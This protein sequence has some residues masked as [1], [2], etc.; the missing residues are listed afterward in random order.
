MLTPR[1]SLILALGCLWHLGYLE[2]FR[3]RQRTVSIPFPGNVFGPIIPTEYI[4]PGLEG[5]CAATAGC[6][7]NT[8]CASAG[9]PKSHSRPK[10]VASAG[11]GCTV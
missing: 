7:E 11:P 3:S 8:G 10:S 9:R 5:S 1:T 4:I 2:E 6:C